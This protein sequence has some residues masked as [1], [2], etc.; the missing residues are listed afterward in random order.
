[1][2]LPLLLSE[3]CQRLNYANLSDVGKCL[4]EQTLNSDPILGGI[5]LTILFVG[6][7]VRY[8]FPVTMLLPFGMALSYTLWLLSG[9]EIYIGIFMFTV[10]IGGAVLIMSILKAINR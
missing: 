4:T 6:L 10:M 7:I 8:N 9:A 5:I 2:Q 1:M 3:F